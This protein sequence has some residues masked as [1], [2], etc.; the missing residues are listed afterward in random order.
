LA[1]GR[2]IHGHPS[3]RTAGARAR[4]SAERAAAALLG[5]VAYFASLSP[6]ER[7]R[8][9]ALCTP[10]TLAAGEMLFEEGQP[11]RG[12]FIVAEGAVEVR[13]ISF[14]GREQIFHTEGPGA[15]LGE[16]PLFDEGGY[17]A[18]AVAI[19]P[20][21]VL[22]LARADLLRLCHRHPAVALAMLKNLARRVRHF[23]GIIGDLAFRPVAE[24]LARYLDG[25]LAGPVT[26][27]ATIQLPLTQAQLAARLGTVRELV[28][29]ALAQLEADGIIAR[30]RSRIVVR[31]PARLAALARGEH[32]PTPGEGLRVT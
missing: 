27:G 17:I 4:T 15:T 6:R 2:R 28:A 29:R 12:L 21:R 19:A 7:S 16:G 18:T 22:F 32:D 14:R 13:Q 9:A 25:T 30:D 1:A 31:D 10:R 3:K 8:L 5:R 11:C 24:R 26:A 20:T 23:A